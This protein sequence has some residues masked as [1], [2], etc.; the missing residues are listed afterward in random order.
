MMGRT[1]A[2]VWLALLQA[3]ATPT[4]DALMK[5]IEAVRAALKPAPTGMTV[6]TA[7][8][9]QA[10]L[11]G[12]AT[13]VLVQPGTYT[14]NFTLKN[15]PTATVVRGLAFDGRATATAAYPKLVA[16][17][18]L[19]PV[20][21]TTAGAHDYTFIGLEFTGVAKDRNVI[22]TGVGATTLAQLP[23]NITFQ[24]VYIHGTTAPFGHR[25][26]YFD[27][28]NGTLV[29]SLCTGFVEQGRDSSCVGVNNGAG[30]YRIEN[31]YIE[32]SGE[33]IIF[34][35]SD[36]AIPNLIPSDIIIRNNVLVKPLEWK[37][38][39][40]SVKNCLE[41]KNARRVLIEGNLCDGVWADAQPGSAV[42]FTVRNQNGGCPWCNVTDVV[43]RCNTIRNV[44]NFGI[45]ILGTDNNNPSGMATDIAIRDNLLQ[46][47]GN[48]ILIDQGTNYT[49]T[50]N[51]IVGVRGRFLA[52][53]GP[54]VTGFTMTGNRLV[55]GTYGIS[56]DGTMPMGM[57][58]LVKAAPGAVFTGNTIERTPFVS[59][60]LGNTIVEPGTIMATDWKC[61]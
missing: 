23:V 41:L 53:S 25:G 17:D 52:L 6:T 33:G 51:V 48:G 1:L 54:T 30:P 29:D 3:P 24:Q 45:N 20:L 32:A 49:I 8:E 18:P 2:L 46:A 27:A 44:Q 22:E 56:G 5:E 60:P 37:T 31:N 58:S 34:G 21:A 38:Y 13:L 12:P 50:G 9:L 7:A 11:D 14:G 59:Y 36:P 10:A 42:L 19:V 15:K 47:V 57:P 61:P 43:F 16:L 55:P 39:P 4:I 26:I 35:G 28:I 40:G